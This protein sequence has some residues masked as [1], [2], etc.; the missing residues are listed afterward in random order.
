MTPDAVVADT[1]AEI[2]GS[3][4]E[5]FDVVDL[6]TTLADRCVEL[7][8]ISA[9]GLMLAARDGGLA[10]AASSSPSVLLLEL[11]EQQNEEGPCPDCFHSGEPLV[12]QPLAT[13]Q[14][15]WPR[16]A[17]CALEAGFRSVHALPI[18]FRGQMI[19]ALNLY[20]LDE[21]PL[22]DSA[23]QAAQ[24][25]A[26]IATV[27]IVQ[28]HALGEAHLLNDQLQHALTSRV[29]IEQAKGLLAGLNRIDLDTAF[30]QLRTYARNH[31][32][33][34]AHVAQEVVA[35]TLSSDALGS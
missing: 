15:R 32:M 4:I 34:L 5:D 19:G 10:V 3:L 8:G 17:P 33:R 28:H 25:L 27:A 12:N 7:F 21:A 30:A 16:F 9:A 24:A 18:R 11:L 14:D 6:L 31:N 23:L 29:A 13:A 22:Q 35:G 2:A 26:D 20:C 1:L